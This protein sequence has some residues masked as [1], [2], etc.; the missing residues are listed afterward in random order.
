MTTDDAVNAVGNEDSSNKKERSDHDGLWKDLIERFFL[1]FAQ[2]RDAGTLRKS[3]HQ[4]KAAF[5]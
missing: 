1:P 5:S 2:T 4:K 3:G